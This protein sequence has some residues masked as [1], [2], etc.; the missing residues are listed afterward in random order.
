ME[1]WK[2]G[3]GELLFLK[4]TAVHCL[5]LRNAQ[6]AINSVEHLDRTIAFSE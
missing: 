4:S 6:F 3:F 5:R 2:I 1:V